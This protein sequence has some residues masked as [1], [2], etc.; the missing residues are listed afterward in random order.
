MQKEQYLISSGGLRTGMEISFHRKN[1]VNFLRAAYIYIAD[2][3][4]ESIK[5]LNQEIPLAETVLRP[6]DESCFMAAVY[7]NGIIAGSC[8]IRFGGSGGLSGRISY[9]DSVTFPEGCISGFLYVEEENGR[10]FLRPL[11]GSGMNKLTIKLS[12][13]YFWNKFIASLKHNSN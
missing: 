10:L 8:T 3:F 9:S 4:N 12:A 11:S 1:K 2:Y 6:V 7:M 5:K 13:E